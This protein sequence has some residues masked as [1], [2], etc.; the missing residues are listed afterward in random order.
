MIKRVKA[1]YGR[2]P[3]IVSIM[4]IL[5]AFLIIFAIDMLIV[6]RGCVWGSDIDWSD[7]H[8]TIPEY[9]RTRYLETGD[10]SPDFAMQLG[11]GQN[12]YNFAY[13]G[14]ANP[15]Y[16]PAYF[17]P[18]MT[19][20]TYIQ[21]ISIIEVLVSAVM[22]YYFFKRHFSGTMPLV[23]ALMFILSG[24]LIFHS[25]R[26]IMFMNYY[27]FLMGLLLIVKRKDS[28]LS[29][30][31]ITLLTYCVLCSSYFYSVGVFVTVGIYIVFNCL[32]EDQRSG[33]KKVMAAL[34]KK[35][36]FAFLGGVCA[37]RFWMPA[38]A[39]IISGRASTSVE[40]SLLELLV[41]TLNLNVLLYTSYAAGLTVISPISIISLLRRGTRSERFLA[42]TM[43]ACVIFPVIIYLFNGT[44]YIDGKAFIPFMPLLLILCGRF[45][46]KFIE[47]TADVRFTLILF[48]VIA[49]MS[50]KQGDYNSLQKIVVMIDTA[51][52]LGVMYLSNKMERRSVISMFAVAAAMIVCV[53]LNCTDTL[54]KKSV[55]DDVY[56]KDVESLVDETLDS[57]TD[58]YRFAENTGS[59]LLVNKVYRTDYLTTNL[60]SSLTNPSYRDFRFFSSGSEVGSRN[61]AIHRQPLNIIFD[62]LMGCRYR[63]VKDD[64][65]LFGER[66]VASSGEY[67]VYKNDYAFPLGFATSDVMK[68]DKYRKLQ[69][70]LQQE[71]ILSNIIIPKEFDAEGK[72][73][74]HTRSLDID[75][76]DL[77]DYDGI[78]YDKRIYTINSKKIIK[79]KVKLDKPVDDGVLLITAFADNRIGK[80]SA[81]KDIIMK[82]NGVK[83]KLTDP[84]WKYNNGNYV[85]S[86]VIS[87]D[88]P[89]TELDM[90][91]SAGIYNISGFE[92]F[93]MDGDA[94]RSAMENKDAF[95][96]ETEDPIG[97]TLSGSI[98]VRKDGWF[99]ITI[100]YDKNFTFLVDGEKVDYYRTDL[101]FMGFP[102]KAGKH[103]IEMTYN[104]PLKKEGRLV[105]FAGIAAVSI[106]LSVFGIADLRRRKK[107][108]TK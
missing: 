43:A 39:A 65:I 104:A 17:M 90:E 20:A 74:E 79:A 24:P 7:Q 29:L 21:L 58:I 54:V 91:F 13:Y 26:H 108:K 66:K 62:T 49:V 101:A 72:N 56:S 63:L 73:D 47:R 6:N 86:Y 42:G 102:I 3:D 36:L 100:P 51:A 2:H 46:V 38:L 48:A 31:M 34:W 12:I 103:T 60:Y 98:D 67:S 99:N 71:A 87:S 9:L 52:T 88:K 44:M 19:M 28:V 40:I 97:D 84:K 105:T 59:E 89:I 107:L 37:A 18:W 93:V 35:G 70:E 94:L 8:F 92:A 82:I 15:L 11:A 96:I 78:E 22:S 81:Q 23:L 32:E 64:P 80:I 77:A 41:P 33:I 4:A 10:W 16:L 14:I 69:F 75:F 45:M 85:F 1:A 25:H 68:V 61:N 5:S 53:A 83:N 30:L 106:L 95:I 50:L 57:D 76:T 27:P 55:I